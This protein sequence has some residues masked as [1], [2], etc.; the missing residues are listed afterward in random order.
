MDSAITAPPL[1][2]FLADAA[3]GRRVIDH[4]WT[5]LDARQRVLVWGPRAG[6]IGL[7]EDLLL[8]WPGDGPAVGIN[9]AGLMTRTRQDGQDSDW[10]Q[11]VD[12]S[13][14]ELAEQVMARGPQGIVVT[15]LHPSMQPALPA[16]LGGPWGFATAVAA[17]SAAEALERFHTLAG[18]AA[19]R[20]DVLVAVSEE[21]TST[22]ITEL[23]QVRQGRVVVPETRLVRG[24]YVA[25]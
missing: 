2:T 8:L 10:V 16:L 5:F 12:L 9:P 1:H 14:A 20:L 7:A 18:E 22:F 24:T 3:S 25:A 13:P 21:G 17:T 23:A 15:Y 6:A 19:A 11:W 4:L